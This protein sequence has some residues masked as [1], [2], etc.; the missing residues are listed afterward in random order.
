MHVF[1]KREI[2]RTLAWSAATAALL[3]LPSHAEAQTQPAPSMQN[4]PTLQ[5]PDAD[6]KKESSSSLPSTGESLSERLDRSDGIIRPPAG[7]DPQISVRPKDPDAGATM[8]VIRPPGPG[9][10]LEPK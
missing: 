2:V 9:Q 8:P 4:A 5:K 6:A 3:L 1:F 7:V 10:S